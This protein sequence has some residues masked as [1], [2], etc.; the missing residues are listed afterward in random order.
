MGIRLELRE[1]LALLAR[2]LPMILKDRELLQI[3]PPCSRDSLGRLD[4]TEQNAPGR[5]PLAVGRRGSAARFLRVNPHQRLGLR[6]NG[7]S[8]RTGLAGEECVSAPGTGVATPTCRVMQSWRP[9]QVCDT[10]IYAAFVQRENQGCAE[11]GM[12]H[13][14]QFRPRP[15]RSIAHWQASTGVDRSSS[16][17]S[18]APG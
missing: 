15:L 9:R 14:H 10:A 18:P 11:G 6:A 16:Q 1:M 7:A 13:P 8:Q 17:C 3:G 12:Y 4:R 5:T 2:L